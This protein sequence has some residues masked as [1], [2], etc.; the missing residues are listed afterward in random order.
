[1]PIAEYLSGGKLKK[2]CPMCLNKFFKKSRNVNP[3]S[4]VDKSFQFEE[5]R[6]ME[7]PINNTIYLKA[8]EFCRFMEADSVQGI[9][10]RI[11]NPQ[12]F[13]SHLIGYRIVAKGHRE[14]GCAPLAGYKRVKINFDDAAIHYAFDQ[15]V[16]S[17]WRNE[18][19]SSEEEKYLCN[20]VEEFLINCKK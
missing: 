18:I 13:I 8:D 19:A 6:R 4:K 17:F 12:D 11:P 9:L 16:I 14:N 15:D 10:S 1:M 20:I 5:L 7:V 3:D 2:L